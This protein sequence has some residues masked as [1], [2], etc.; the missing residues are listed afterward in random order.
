M[1]KKYIKNFMLRDQK[2]LI[3]IS[4]CGHVSH[5][6]LKNYIA[7]S[8][9]KNYCRDGLVT[10]EVFNKTNGEQLVGYKLTNQ[11]RQFVEKNYGFDKHQ[12]AQSLNHDLGISDKYFSLTEQEQSSW[13]TETQLRNQLQDEIDRLRNSE[14]DRWHELTEMMEKREISVADCSYVQ[15]GVTIAYEV[16]TNSYGR[17]ELQAKEEYG[18]VMNISIEYG[19]V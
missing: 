2:A 1:G 10:K 18:N 15:G 16:V 12:I 19:R 6:Q 3:S 14:V 13:Q 9:I 17:A 5:S 7:D 8:R 11:G 4:R